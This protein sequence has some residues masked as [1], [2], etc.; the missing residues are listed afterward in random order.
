M[1]DLDPFAASIL[2][3][4][5]QVPEAMT[6]VRS[7]LLGLLETEGTVES[8]EI[9]RPILAPESHLSEISQNLTE[10]TAANHG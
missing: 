9:V 5:A 1:K 2:N 8:Q 4:W 6:D 3:V 10:V 7:K